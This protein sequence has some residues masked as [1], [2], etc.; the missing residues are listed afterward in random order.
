M[1]MDPF[2]SDV[3]ENSKKIRATFYNKNSTPKT[4]LPGDVDLILDS[5]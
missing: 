5:N 4:L 3:S 2:H 1:K